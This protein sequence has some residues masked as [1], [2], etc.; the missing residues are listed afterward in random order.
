MISFQDLIV[1]IARFF[2]TIHFVN[3]W[4]VSVIQ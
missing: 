1:L 4:N 3:S 2:E